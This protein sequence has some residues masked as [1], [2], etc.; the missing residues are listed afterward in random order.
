MRPTHYYYQTREGSSKEPR[1]VHFLYFYL[2]L[3]SSSIHNENAGAPW[4]HGRYR[5]WPILL[6]PKTNAKTPTNRLF[7][8][9]KL[10]IVSVYVN[11]IM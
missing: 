5:Q 6:P 4:E 8:E 3:V 11:D 10:I 9:P 7:S 2:P 1:R